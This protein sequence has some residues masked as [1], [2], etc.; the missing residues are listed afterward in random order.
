M[1]AVVNESIFRNEQNNAKGR[2]NIFQGTEPVE[3]VAVGGV[4]DEEIAAAQL[5]RGWGGQV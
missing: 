3:I 5:Q 2:E 4:Q 1:L